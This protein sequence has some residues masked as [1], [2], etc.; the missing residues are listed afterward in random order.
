MVRLEQ[1]LKKEKLIY[2]ERSPQVAGIYSAIADLNVSQGLL[3]EAETYA[4]QSLSLMEIA[5]GKE[6]YGTGYMEAVLGEILMRRGKLKEAEARMRH[7]LETYSKTLPPDHQL[8]ASAEYFLGEI[9][10]REGRLGDAEVTLTTSMDRWKRVTAA[11]WRSMRSQSALGEVLYREHKYTGAE[12]YLSQSY[13]ALASD[14]KADRNTRV[15]ARERVVR[16]YRERGELQKLQALLSGTQ[17]PGNV[18]MK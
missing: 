13:K 17:Q 3:D 11:P 8:I 18:A 4:R 16:F 10:L 2:G 9:L 12:R 6:R 14:E 1:V 15:Q 5:P 7:S